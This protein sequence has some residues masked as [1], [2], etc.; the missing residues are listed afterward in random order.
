MP[1]FIIFKNGKK[2]REIV[3]ANF[4]KLKQAISEIAASVE[5]GK[6]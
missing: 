1:T 3:G 5:G 2:E 6:A 4:S